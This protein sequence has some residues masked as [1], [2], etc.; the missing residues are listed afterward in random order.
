MVDQKSR[1][2]AID[3]T[4]PARQ[5]RFSKINKLHYIAIWEHRFIIGVDSFEESL[6]RPLS[7]L[8]A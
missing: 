1:Y 3:S 6:L 4:Y 2:L 7:F 8:Q 5:S